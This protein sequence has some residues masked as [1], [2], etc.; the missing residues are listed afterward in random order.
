MAPDTTSSLEEV[1]IQS[2]G[3]IQIEGDLVVSTNLERDSPPGIVFLHGFPSGDVRAERVGGDMAELCERAARE[4]NWNALTVRFR[5][6][7]SSGGEFS[8]ARWVDDASAAIRFIRSETASKRVW[9]CGFGTGGSVGL[10]AAA[11]D[12]EVCGVAVVGAPADFNDWAE[13]PERLL[14]HAKDVGAIKTASFPPNLERWQLE[15]KEVQAVEAAER[16]APRPLLVLHGSE[17][18]AVPHFDARLVA[19]AHGSADLRFIQ[20]GGH[21]LRH[22]PRAIAV[23]LGW[24]NFQGTGDQDLLPSEE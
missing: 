19:D 10:V 2:S 6:C 12:A 4:M 9:I 18:E 7:G 13:K 5:G 15:L 3:G 23:L 16:F 24:L 21:Q 17:D 14:K 22:D 1:T 20:S 8:L 11:D